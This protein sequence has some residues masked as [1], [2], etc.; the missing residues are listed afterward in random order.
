MSL[1][2]KSYLRQR[3]IY[4]PNLVWLIR[5][6]LYLAIGQ[7]FDFETSSCTNKMELCLTVE[8]KLAHR[9]FKLTDVVR[10]K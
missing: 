2:L 10:Q 7:I 9:K 6:K 5:K 8:I 1:I 3:I 4:E